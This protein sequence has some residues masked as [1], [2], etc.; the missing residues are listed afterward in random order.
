MERNH[1]KEKYTQVWGDIVS[2]KELV[3]SAAIGIG[4][5][6]G[7]FF[8]G[9]YIFNNVLT[10]LEEDLANGYAL[11]VGVSGVF[12]SGFIS[13]SLFKPK[14]IIEEKME[15]EEIADVLKAAGMTVEEEAK[16][17]AEAPEDV[18]AEMEELELYG[19]LALIP[20]DSKN[21]KPIYKEK[22]EG[23]R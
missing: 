19:L 14:R 12:I 18:I 1:S 4:V 17:L 11:L 6:M 22:L 9:K 2:L 5:T 21:Y 20:E 8:L 23:D 13:A 7:M 15:Q 10:N 3:Y 16:A